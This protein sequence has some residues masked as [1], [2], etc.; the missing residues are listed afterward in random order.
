MADLAGDQ[1]YKK[2]ARLDGCKA[3]NEDDPKELYLN[4]TWRP[5]MSITGASGLPDIKIAGNVIRAST[6]ARISMRL[7]PSC[8]PSKATEAIKKA[9]TTDVPYNLKVDVGDGHEGQ[10]WCMKEM[11]PWLDT[12]MRKAGSDFFDGKDTGTYG[13]GGS[14]PFLC[15][16]GNMYPAAVILAF[17]L[18]GPYANAHAPNECINL[19]YAKKLTCALSHMIASVGAKE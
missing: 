5:N 12:A 18:I 11:E 15:E 14:I 17:G 16:L 4:N 6:S 7:P 9:L 2:Y 8:N 13:M 10:G 1:L 19:A 3:M